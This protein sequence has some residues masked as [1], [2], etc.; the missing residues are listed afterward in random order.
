[1]S[2]IFWQKMDYWARNISP[3]G[4]T[5]LLV[6]MSVVPTSI[7]GY[8]SVVPVLALMAIYHWAV[9]RPNLLPLIAVFALGLMQDILTGTPLG[10]YVL[11]FL[12]V[13]G[14]VLFQRRFIAGKSFF[15]YWF[16]FAIVALGAAVESW[17]LASIWNFALM[18]IRAVFFQYLVSLG[19]CPLIAWLFL[20]WQ[21]A[22][23][24]QD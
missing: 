4:L 2:S 10:I 6:L 16:G 7:P 17:V 15:I 23:L 20:R 8:R 24:P 12:S 13:Y 9:Y 1:M 18:D 11:V 14:V 3:F 19:V 22:F 5:L 21:Q